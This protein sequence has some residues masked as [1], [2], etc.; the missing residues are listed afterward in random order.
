VATLDFTDDLAIVIGDDFQY[1]FEFQD[2][3]CDP[4]DQEANTFEATITRNDVLIETFTVDVV[5]ELVTIS[6]SEV[7][8]A[9]LT[10]KKSN[11]KWRLRRTE[12]DLTTT[13][14]S[15]DAE[16]VEL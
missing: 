4:I 7:E 5:G 11:V 9:A 16:I 15:G 13:V 2:A 10:P 6:L 12:G 3:N 1:T 8:T 14:V